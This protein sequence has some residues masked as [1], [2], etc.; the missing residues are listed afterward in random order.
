MAGG[1]SRA[2]G[3]RHETVAYTTPFE[4]R[5]SQIYTAM[6]YVASISIELSFLEPIVLVDPTTTTH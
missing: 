4:A 1:N 5:T 6:T 3:G 2:M